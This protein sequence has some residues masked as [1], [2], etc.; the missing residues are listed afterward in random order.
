MDEGRSEL[1]LLLTAVRASDT[2]VPPRLE[3]AVRR[4]RRPLRIQVT[5]RSRA[6]KTTVQ[7]ALALLA[8]EET[9]SVDV[10]GQPEP[11]LDGDLVLYILAGA[12]HPADRAV[13]ATVPPERML[14]VLNKADAIGSRWSD[15][16]TAA[17]RCAEEFG[18][19]V[20]PVVATL[21]A[22][23]RSGI[24]TDAERATL[25]RHRDHPDPTF[26]LVPERFTDPAFGSDTADRK[27]LL[28]RWPLPGLAC[29][30]SALRY[31]PELSS[32]RILQILHAASGID[33]L[34]ADLRRRCEAHAARRGGELLDELTRLAA[35]RIPARDRIETYL[36]GD[37]AL[38]LGL[39]AGLSSPALARLPSTDPAPTDPDQALAHA[40]H[41]RAVVAAD[42]TPD[43]RRAAL[44]I[45][46]GYIR[47]W[48]RLT[49]ARL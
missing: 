1:E 37:E 20:H 39:R 32:G 43:A 46:D 41:W 2:P 10:P 25:C 45:H 4:W 44:R 33:P 48:E 7:R 28:A 34:H 13:L 8:A 26:A 30:L 17:E 16:V 9:A 31:R 15:A 49:D 22:H 3:A 5:G 47:L 24:V 23:T 29:A 42:I 6:G 36:R 40:A 35:C 12:P 38:A 19:A 27:A 21:A 11:V 18:M 14:L